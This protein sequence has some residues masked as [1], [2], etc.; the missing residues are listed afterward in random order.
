MRES[1]VIYVIAFILFTISVFLGINYWIIIKKIQKQELLKQ[2]SNLV[3][4]P[5]P[6][7]TIA[8]MQ[9]LGTNWKD[10]KKMGEGSFAGQTILMFISDGVLLKDPIEIKTRTGEVLATSIVAFRGYYYDISS[11]KQSVIVPMLIKLPDNRNYHP[12]YINSV[13]W[14]QTEL[15]VKISSDPQL[16]G[17]SKGMLMKIGTYDQVLDKDMNKMDKQSIRYTVLQQLDKYNKSWQTEVNKFYTNGDPLVE[18][19]FPFTYFS[20]VKQNVTGL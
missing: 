17:A 11:Q 9:Q 6:T 13:T 8:T 19:V 16:F 18:I 14:N 2:T 15:A 20:I 10:Y 1:R 3:Q 7:E 4:R 5:H 12:A